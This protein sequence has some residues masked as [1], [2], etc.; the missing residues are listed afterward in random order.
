MNS[1]IGTLSTTLLLTG[2]S[3]LASA[4]ALAGADPA[5]DNSGIRV[6]YGDLDLSKPPDVAKLYRRIERAAN[7][8]C[9]SSGSVS[10]VKRCMQKTI[11][12]TVT[13]INR[14]PLSAFY[15]DHAKHELASR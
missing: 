15:W 3:A 7:M 10:L 8:I 2:L 4:N 5:E 1:R 9:E 6:R 11:E 13:R 12:D 14:P